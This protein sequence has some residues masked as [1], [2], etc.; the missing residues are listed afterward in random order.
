MNRILLFHL[1]LFSTIS[2]V[3]CGPSG[4]FDTA[5]VH[6]TVT[7]DGQPV[8][9]GTIDFTPIAGGD[10][11]M[12]GKPAAARI[13]EDGTFS[14]GTYGDSDGV[15]PGK[16]RVRYSAPLPEDT[17]ENANKAPSPFTGLQIEPSEI[18]VQA[19]DNKIE[20]FLKKSK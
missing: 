15:V 18:D 20:F 11:Q 4:A 14:A 13:N 8:T 5:P 6:G 10:S 19:G 1:I 7:F 17:R 2:L 9:E 12:T 16:K 3:G